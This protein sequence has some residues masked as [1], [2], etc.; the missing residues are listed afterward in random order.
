MTFA[1]NNSTRGDAAVG[2]SGADPNGQDPDQVLLSVLREAFGTEVVVGYEVLQEIVQENAIGKKLR[3]RLLARPLADEIKDDSNGASSS[4]SSITKAELSP[5]HRQTAVL[6]LFVKQIRLVDYL[7]KKKDWADLRRTLLYARTEIRFYREVLPRLLDATTKTSTGAGASTTLG[8]T[9]WTPRV[10]LARCDL[11]GWIEDGEVASDSAG[12]SYPNGFD[13][14]QHHATVRQNDPAHSG[15]GG[16][17]VMECIRVSEGPNTAAAATTTTTAH[18]EAAASAG[19]YYQDSPL[20]PDQSWQC[21]RAVARMHA[22]AWQDVGLLEVCQTRLS[23]ASFHLKMRNPLELEGIVDSWEGFYVAFLPHLECEGL[24]GESCANLGQRLQR[25][26]RYVSD[27]VSPGPS[28]R[29]ATLIH[30]DYK[31]LNVFLPLE[32]GGNSG[33]A[34][35]P[36]LCGNGGCLLVDFAST[37]VGL[38]MSDLAMH[39]HHAVLPEHLEG[40]GEERLVRSYWEHLR[41]LLRQTTSEGSDEDGGFCDYPWEVAW[42]HYKLAVVDYLRFF[43]GRMWK[44]ATPSTMRQKK[45][46]K[47]VSLINRSV[48]AAM[49][50]LRVAERF[51]TEIEAEYYAV[52]RERRHDA[53]RFPQVTSC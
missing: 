31:S 4:A 37:G 34:K 42:R 24:A 35:H 5:A 16:W 17:I 8:S 12:P 45:L 33:E 43:V 3:V 21:L 27:Q 15:K 36:E 7:Y 22:A 20:T 29:Y 51:L 39:I 1:Y 25:I 23:R 30:G 26:A 28:D 18:T 47:N 52:S 14:Y 2:G 6:L 46:N 38:G 40:G 41:S 50:F 48:P 9:M 10:H 32:C 13:K 11:E 49:A 53:S 19:C 44:S